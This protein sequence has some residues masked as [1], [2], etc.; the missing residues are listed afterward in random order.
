MYRR[1][2]GDQRASV[3]QNGYLEDAVDMSFDL[4]FDRNEKSVQK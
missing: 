2:L 4:I 1:F 3:G